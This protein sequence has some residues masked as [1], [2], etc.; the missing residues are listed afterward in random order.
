ML[1]IPKIFRAKGVGGILQAIAWRATAVKPRMLPLCIELVKERH[2]LEIGGPS[3]LFM[4]KG[5]LP[6]YPHIARLDNCNFNRNTVWENTITEGYTFKYDKNRPA[7]CQYV[8]EA[9]NL[10]GIPSNSYSFVLASH[11]V[12]HTANPISA[13]KEWIRVLEPNGKLL[14]ITPHLEGTFDH[15]R[16]ITDLRHLIEDNQLETREDDK[17]HLAEILKLHDLDRDWGAS[18]FKTFK[19]RSERNFEFRCLHHHVFDTKLVV[20]MLDYTGLQILEVE[21]IR[22]FHIIVVAQKVSDGVTTEN[23]A[24]LSSTAKWRQNSPFKMDHI[25]E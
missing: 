11:V 1:V 20:D 15:R 24:F 8:S 5:S 9:A 13:V 6:L 3:P 22:P 23:Q 7:G 18:D 25:G 16:P 19:E 14:L 17:T 4:R 12:E 21:P 2:G 10:Q